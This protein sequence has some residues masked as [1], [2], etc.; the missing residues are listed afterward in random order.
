MTVA[1]IQAFV[2]LFGM[3]EDRRLI[4]SFSFGE[5]TGLT[6]VNVLPFRFTFRKGDIFPLAF[7]F[8]L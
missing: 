1:M 5:E 8:N 6:L 3:K 2:T 4:V 7:R